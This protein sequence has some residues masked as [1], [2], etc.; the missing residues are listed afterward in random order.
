MKLIYGR[1]GTGKTEYVFND[2][3]N[4]IKSEN[5]IYIITPEQFSFTAEKRLLDTLEE[6]AVLKVEVLS[7]ERMAYRVINETISNIDYKIE[8]SG[9]SMIIFDAI[10]KEQKNLKFL[11]K[12]I[13]NVETI[14]KQITEFKKHNI[15]V[16]TLKKQVEETEDEYLKLKLN[17]ML[18][19]YT[20]F[21]EVIEGK[22]LDEN[23]VLTI[24]DENIEK[25]HL[26]DNA[27]F[28]IDE[29]AGFTK[30]EY[31][32]IK[33]LEKVAKELYITICTDSLRVEKS[34]EADIFYDNK[35]AIQTLCNISEIDKKEQ[36]YLEK[37][38]RFKNEELAFMEKNIFGIPYKTYD[39]ENR[40]IELRYADNQ[41][42]EVE[43]VASKIIKL[44]RD[45]GYRF[46]DIAVICNNIDIYSSLCKVIFNEY[47]IPVFI[48]EK[49]EITQNII[50]KYILGILDIFA[51]NWSY[52]AVFNYIKTGITGIDN[53][54]ELENYCLKWG[55]QGKKFYNEPWNYEKKKQEVVDSKNNKSLGKHDLQGDEQDLNYQR[56][57]HILITP[58]LKLKEEIVDNKTVEQI[59]SLLYSFLIEHLLDENMNLKEELR[60][61]ENVDAFNLI[62]NVLEEMSQIFKDK[63]ISFENY[64]NLLRTGIATKE[65]NQIPNSNDHVIVGDVNRSKTHK[66][67]AVFIIG[68][69][70][71]VFPR[72]TTTEGFLNDKDREKLKD[73]GLELAKGIKEKMYEENFN[74]YKAF[75]TAEEK[76]YISY[77]A[78][79]INGDNLRKSLII[80][81]IKKVFP[82]LTEQKVQEDEVLTKN[83]TFSKL[84]NHI[85]EEEWYEVYEWYNKHYNSKLR[86]AMEGNEYTNVPTNINAENIQKLYGNTLK[87]S[88]S[89]LEKYAACPFSYYLTYGLR[90][91]SK[92]KFDVSPIDTGSFMHD[93]IDKFFKQLQE[94]SISVKDVNEDIIKKIVDNIIEEKLMFGSKFT[95]APKY[96]I[97]CERLSKVLYTSIKYIIESLKDSSFEVL[98]TEV[99]FNNKE[100][101][102][103]SSIN[104]TTDDGKHIQIEGKIDRIDIAELPDGKYIRIIDYKSKSKDIDLNKVISGL[105]LQLITYIDAICENENVMPAGALYYGLVE[106]QLKKGRLDTKDKGEIEK[107]IKQN[108]K[109]NGLILAD[110]NII[111]AMDNSFDGVS[112]NKIPV[113]IDKKTNEIKESSNLVTREEFE[114]LQKY[115]NKIIKQIANEI[116]SG[117][118][119]LKPYYNNKLMSKTPCSYCEFKSICQF[120]PK[121]KNNNYRFIPN[122]EREKIMDKIKA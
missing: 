49:K 60:T 63:K 110:I 91:S 100:G 5:K 50:I 84:L 70:D 65:L 48:D 24:L 108:Y 19:M 43:N 13:D 10:N 99:A 69:N 12:S 68:V 8:K 56:E 117:N 112:S 95:L 23:D 29:F 31:E 57:Q 103:Y 61:D 6:G 18:I 42:I 40:N 120:N 33:K 30:Q 28:Y 16:E 119:E 17:D 55:I 38:H 2:I 64:L 113:E 81:R 11:G 35:Q 74:I 47:E 121:F 72:A 44:V 118:I 67:R 111:K 109:M 79:D 15:N 54:Y 1:A 80:S 62:T 96:K 116:L 97:M 75:S 104:L 105:Q 89:K 101:S 58:L 78:S 82:K 21:E 114:N 86:K 37:K 85:G 122:M 51:K 71:G 66:V 34:P 3:K 14:I 83:I 76:L 93:V 32:V 98:G 46:N 36:I 102:K 88:I 77:S 90:L 4:K 9:K 59:S 106:P 115:A 52:E 27:V 39:K 20:K 92:E 94:E 87:T 7:F 41:Y 25:S 107:L 53:I 73:N 22:F 26:F 45:E